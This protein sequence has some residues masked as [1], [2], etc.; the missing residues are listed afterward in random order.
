M[1][2]EINVSTVIAGVGASAIVIGAATYVVRE[3]TVLARDLLHF[4]KDLDK[5]EAKAAAVELRQTEDRR[6]LGHLT[7]QV[8]EIKETLAA[9]VK[10][11]AKCH[12]RLFSNPTMLAVKPPSR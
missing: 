6:D 4:A 2:V 3:L 5:A 7:A 9:T 10:V 12:S 8:E 1:L 11:A